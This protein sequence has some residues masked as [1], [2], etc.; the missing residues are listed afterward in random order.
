VAD[1]SEYHGGTLK[2]HVVTEELQYYLRK[3]PGI[4]N[5]FRLL[6]AYGWEGGRGERNG[7]WKELAARVPL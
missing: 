7:W 5:V 3:G 1:R 4:V 2:L 6:D